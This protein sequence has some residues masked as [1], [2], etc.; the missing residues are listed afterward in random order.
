MKNDSNNV[1]TVEVNDQ[2]EFVVIWSWFDDSYVI[3]I[4]R[5]IG[6]AIEIKYF[7]THAECSK[8]IKYQEAR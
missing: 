2:T 5:H 3:K 7:G 8:W 4:L 1:T 6:S